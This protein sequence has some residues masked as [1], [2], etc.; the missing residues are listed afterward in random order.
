MVKVTDRSGFGARLHGC[1][2]ELYVT[3]DE[4]LDLSV[5]QFF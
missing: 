4:S 5:P 3:S 1:T 2:F